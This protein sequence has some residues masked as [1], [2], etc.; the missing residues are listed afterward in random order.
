[1]RDGTPNGYSILSI[2]GNRY[3]VRYKVARRPA[4]YQMNIFAPD[5]VTAGRAGETEILVNVFSGSDRS[6][7][8][9]RLRPEGAWLP[10]TRVERPD[11]Y[12]LEQ[13]RREL[14][15]PT[16]PTRPLPPADPSKHLWRATLPPAPATGTTLIEVRTVDMFGATHTGRRSIRIE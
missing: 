8:E 11:P 7:V 6:R 9:M 12:F 15:A 10:M 13:K 4:D 5:A 2:A 3:Q 16:P 14:A 1:M